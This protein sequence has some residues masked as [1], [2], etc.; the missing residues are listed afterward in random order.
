MDLD[1]NYVIGRGRLYFDR[2]LDGTKTK[3]GEMYFGNTPELASSGDIEE[4]EHY[5]SE[6]GLKELDAS[7]TL[8]ITSEITF[9]TDN[10]SDDNVAL[11]NT[12]TKAIS[13]AVAAVGATQD[14]Y[15][16]K[17]GYIQVGESPSRPF[18]RKNLTSVAIVAKANSGPRATGTITVATNPSADD[19]ITLNGVVATFKASGATSVQINIG[20]TTAETAANIAAHVNSRSAAFGMTATVAGNVVTLRAI[21]GGTAGNSLTLA[22]SGTHPTLSGAT[23]AGGTQTLT[24]ATT[25]DINLAEGRVQV[26]HTAT[27]LD[28]GDQVTITYSAPAVSEVV[29]ASKN[30][31]IYGALRFIADNPVGGNKDFYWPYV[32][33]SPN[34][35]FA[36]KGD[37]WQS[38]SFTAK[39]LK[40]DAVTERVYQTPG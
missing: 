23:L 32:K 22:K 38:M 20:G 31:S 3:S 21:V 5:S 35:D 19:T 10:I 6:G 12:G 17:G 24:L 11:W 30:A 8:S 33:L 16:R 36:L 15:I 40:L 7:V 13:A 1:N 14:A 28:E 39:I 2:F 29:V 18:G 4:L 27:E 25:F 26:L 34:G 37:D 9:T